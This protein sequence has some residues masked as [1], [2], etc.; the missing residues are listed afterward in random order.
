MK[1]CLMAAFCALILVHVLAGGANAVT[2]VQKQAAIDAGLAWL[3][4]TQYASGYWPGSGYNTHWGTASAVAAFAEE[5]HTINSGTAYSPNVQS[6]VNWLMT[7]AMTVG[8]SPQPA[9]NPDT[10]G[11]GIGVRWIGGAGENMVNGTAVAAIVA[12]TTPGDTV[13]TGSLAGWSYG[14]VVQDVLDY[15]AYGQIDSTTGP[16]RGGWGYSANASY[17]DEQYTSLWT[18]TALQ[19][20]ATWGTM[21]PGFVGG[22]LNNYYLPAVQ[23]L[24]GGPTH[25]GSKWSPVN[26]YITVGNSGVLLEEFATVGRGPGDPYVD[27]ALNYVNGQWNTTGSSWDGNFGNAY[28]MWAL[29]RGLSN[30]IGVDD[31]STI[32][33]WRYGSLVMDPGDTHTWFEE[34]NQYL[35]DTQIGGGYWNA[36]GMWSN[37]QTTAWYLNILNAEPQ[38]AIPEPLSMIFFGTGLAAVLGQA[39]RRARRTKRLDERRA[40]S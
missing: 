24:S 39:R 6:G 37:Y 13:T 23:Y 16:Y 22:E 1:R 5:G 4:S 3:A 14:Q 32:T 25:G 21:V 31:A 38:Q 35:C 17:G 12:A 28:A 34:Y 9:G 26:T 29:Y 15:Q 36:Y 27:L 33:N 7:Q 30:T 2:E 20:A 8:I 19:Y 10:N 18:A 11:N 40:R